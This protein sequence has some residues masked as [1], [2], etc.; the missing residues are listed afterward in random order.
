MNILQKIF[1]EHYEEMIYLQHPRDAIVENVEKMIHCGDPSYGGAMYIC[2]NCGNFKFTAF[3]CH[4]RF[5]PTCGNMYSIDRTTAMSF[6]IIDVQHRH[7]V[8]TIDDSLLPFFGSQQ[9]D[10]SYVP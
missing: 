6:K 7:C 1:I 4:S 5:C 2:P 9:R 8:F 10:F 3:R